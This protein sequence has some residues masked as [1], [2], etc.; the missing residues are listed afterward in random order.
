MAGTRVPRGAAGRPGRARPAGDDHADKA[1][2]R[3]GRARSRSRSRRSTSSA[4]RSRPRC[5]WR[6]WIGRCCGCS[7]TGCRRSARSSTTRRGPAAF[8][9]ESTNTFR[10]AAGDGAGARGGRRG[11]GAAGGAAGRRERRRE[12][13]PPSRRSGEVARLMPRRRGRRR[14][15]EPASRPAERRRAGRWHGRPRL[16]RHGRGGAWPRRRPRSERRRHGR[17]RS[18]C[19]ADA[20]RRT[21]RGGQAVDSR[22]SDGRSREL[23]RG[24]ACDGGGRAGASRAPRAVRR[25]GLLEPGGR[26]RQGRQG[27]RQVPR[28]DGPLASTA[29]PPGASPAPTRSS[30]RRTA[31][32]AV[33][34]DF[35]VDLKAPAVAHPGGQAP[36]HR[37]RS[38]TRA[39]S[40]TVDLRLTVYAGGREVVQPKTLDVKADGVDEVLFDPFEVPD[41]D[42]VRLTLGRDARAT[43]TT[44]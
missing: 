38:T 9:T 21:G 18:R 10:Y 4:S 44:S 8:A 19:A 43:R 33:R 3:A 12:R 34:K 31:D 14:R 16:A 25:D 17:R 30:A 27:P 39:S 32:L 5:R 24:V 29:S 23:G 11:R 28:P 26:H 42:E 2:G 15:G 41:G 22:A 6:W 37:P 36:V 35:F 13:G 1:G 20:V 7:A 40:G